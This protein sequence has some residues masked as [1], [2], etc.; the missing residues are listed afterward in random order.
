MKPGLYPCQQVHAHTHPMEQTLRVPRG[1]TEREKWPV[2]SQTGRDTS[3]LWPLPSA[4]R[5]AGCPQTTRFLSAD[6]AKISP[7]FSPRPCAGV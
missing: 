5:S 7:D 3:H 1:G 2:G 4:G 6:A